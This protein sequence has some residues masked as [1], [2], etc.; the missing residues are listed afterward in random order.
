MKSKDINEI[1]HKHLKDYHDLHNV[2]TSDKLL[3]YLNKIALDSYNKALNDS[4]SEVTRIEII[5]HTPN[6][7]RGRFLVEINIKSIDFSIQDLNRTLKIFI[8]K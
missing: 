5:D 8:K 6:I 7:E 1:I 2:T 4:I 3:P